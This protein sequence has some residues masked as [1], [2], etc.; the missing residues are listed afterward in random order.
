MTSPTVA[1]QNLDIL[2][3]VELSPTILTLNINLKMQ[4]N[5][6]AT[7][8]KPSAKQMVAATIIVTSYCMQSFYK[9]RIDRVVCTALFDTGVGSKRRLTSEQVS[10][11]LFILPTFDTPGGTTF[12]SSPHSSPIGSL[13]AVRI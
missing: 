11:N 13:S 10:G 6:G 5:V 9:E 12:A 3:L 4:Q 1:H 7:G 8:H 2:L